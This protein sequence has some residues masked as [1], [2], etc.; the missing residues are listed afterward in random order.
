MVEEFHRKIFVEGIV[1]S[2]FDGNQEHAL[3]EK[4]HPSIAVGLFDMSAGG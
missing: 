2:E 4:C 1:E 3:T